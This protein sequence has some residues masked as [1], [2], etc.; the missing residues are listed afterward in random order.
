VATELPQVV[1]TARVGGTLRATTGAWDQTG[2]TFTFQWLR[3]GAPISK[4]RG[5]EYKLKGGDVGH[6]FSIRVTATRP[7]GASGVATSAAT[8]PVVR[9]R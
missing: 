7:S 5:T 3:D 9:A 8:A 4:E 1:G 6:R 2:L